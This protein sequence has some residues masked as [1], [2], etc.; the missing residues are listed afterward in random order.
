[1]HKLSVSNIAWSGPDE[2]VFSL[3]QAIGVEGVE[4]APTKLAP[5]DVLEEAHFL[6]YRDKCAQF[7]LLISS[8][9]AIFFGRPE[10]QLLGDAAQFK[11]FTKHFRRILRYAEVAGASCLVFGA[12]KN[13]L[14]LSLS[15]E[16]AFDLAVTRLESLATVAWEYGV[17]IAIEPVPHIY[18]GE[19]LTRYADVL[20]LVKAVN[21]PGVSINL[22][23]ACVWSAGDSI[24]EAIY[25]SRD[26]FCHFHVS[27]QMLGSFEHPDPRHLEAA[28][29]LSSIDYPAWVCIE[30]KQNDDL[31]KN[32]EDA[33]CFTKAVYFSDDHL[34]LC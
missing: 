15:L 24:S 23:T 29:A 10:L 6:K 32:I 16:S 18:G 5:W 9:Q 14:L 28:M 13:R 27:Q 21:R 7:G 22:D 3:L 34:Q 25:D 17:R 1:M 4:I 11:D 20:R 8:F 12:P 31:R 2:V 33:V 30:M 26:S 19:F